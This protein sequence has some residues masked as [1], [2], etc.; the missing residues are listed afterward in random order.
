MRPWFDWMAVR[1]VANWFF[2][3]SRAW[4]AGLAAEGSVERFNSLLG[5]AAGNLRNT[6][7]ILDALARMQSRYLSAENTW[8]S[9]V[10]GG[11]KTPERLVRLELERFNASK[12]LMAMRRVFLPLRRSV[13][14]IDWDIAAPADVQR[15][16]GL[17]LQ[18]DAIAYPA[19]ASVRVERSSPVAGAKGQEFW[20]R[21]PSPVRSTG[22]T[23]WAHVFMP[24][25]RPARGVVVSLHGVVMEPEMWPLADLA[26]GLV[27]RGYCVIRPEGPWHGRRRLNNHFGGETIFARGILGFVELFEA[28]VMET[29]L[30][31]RWAREAVSHHV[32]IA[33][34]SLGALTAQIVASVCHHW[35]NEMR[36]DGALLIT[37]TGDLVKGA[38]K[39]SLASELAIE[40]RLTSAGWSALELDR[41][42]PL[43][44]PA[45][46]P[47]IDPRRI[48]MTLGEADTV[49]PFDGGKA[50]AQRWDIPPENLFIGCQGHFSTALGLYRNSVPVDRAAKIFTD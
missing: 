23:A 42:R 20:I 15:A 30:W 36:P 29:A 34:V 44:E 3:L 40:E 47:T 14:Q 17:R 26:D 4:A 45:Q 48:V 33:G 50:L 35:P 12:E 5:A 1:I 28:W 43:V 10:F 24:P 13:R 27:D 16:H 37:T 6:E 19:P 11:E 21:M 25:K 22:D 31:I 8:Q 32:S 2:P 41:W 49:T 39:G 38:L 46:E 9:A 18:A 7:K